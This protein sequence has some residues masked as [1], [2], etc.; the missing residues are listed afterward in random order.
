MSK[1][2]LIWSASNFNACNR[3]AK[4]LISFYFFSLFSNWFIRAVNCAVTVWLKHCAITTGSVVGGR[5][6][7]ARR[8]DL[9]IAPASQYYY[10]L[11]GWTGSKHFNRSLRLYAQRR[12][13]Q[14]LTSHCLYD[15][16]TVCL[17]LIKRI[18]LFCLSVLFLV[19]VRYKLL[20]IINLWWSS[21]W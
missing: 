21:S 11:V 6:W 8:V 7:R 9:I 20:S 10:A 14:R 5:C 15:P 1:I 13:A 16:T 3:I 18:S 17:S 4:V 2:L 12:F 19:S